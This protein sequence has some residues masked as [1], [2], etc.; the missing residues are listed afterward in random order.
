MEPTLDAVIAILE[1]INDDVDYET[2]TDL[3]D[4]RSLTSF[5]IL[6]IISA[7]DEEFDVS[8]PAKDIVPANF[9]SAQAILELIARLAEED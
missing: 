1:D 4:S 6:A 8:V 2:C 7:I 3:V 5:D 9:N